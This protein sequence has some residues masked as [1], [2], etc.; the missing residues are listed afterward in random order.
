MKKNEETKNEGIGIVT[1]VFLIIVALIGFYLFY[2]YHRP[3]N[4]VSI[5]LESP[6]PLSESPKK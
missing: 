2:S 1:I 3:T 4:S 6:S 5:P